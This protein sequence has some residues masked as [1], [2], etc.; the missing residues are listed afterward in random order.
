MKNS[1]TS[2]LGVGIDIEE[3]GRFENLPFR[4][5]K[6]FYEKIFTQGEISYCLTRSNPYQHFAARFCAKEAAVKA[7]GGKIKDLRKITIRKDPEGRPLL[8]AKS[9]PD[10]TLHTSFSHTKNHAIAFVIAYSNH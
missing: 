2:I 5:N 8:E 4:K 9:L 10:V 7:L 3:I 6:A 1:R